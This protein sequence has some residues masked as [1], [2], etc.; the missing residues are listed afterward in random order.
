MIKRNLLMTAM[1]LSVML[2]GCGSDDSAS[3]STPPVPKP[4]VVDKPEYVWGAPSEDEKALNKTVQFAIVGGFTPLQEGES[5][6]KVHEGY[7]IENGD[8]LPTKMVE[9]AA[10]KGYKVDWI[11]PP[12][13]VNMAGVK[14]DTVRPDLFQPG[15]GSVLD[16]LI[17][18]ADHYD[19]DIQF[20]K[21]DVL[22]TYWVT[23]IE[24]V[25]GD[26]EQVDPER[27]GETQG[28][29]W[30]Y[31]YASSAWEYNKKANPFG[32]FTDGTTGHYFNEEDSYVRIDHQAL[33]NNVSI[34]LMPAQPGE[35]DIRRQKYQREQ[36]RLAAYGGK[37]IIPEVIIDFKPAKY[38]DT[39]EVLEPN[40]RAVF[41][42]IEITAHNLR[43]DIYQP[44]VLT[45]T[46]ILLSL[47][48]QRPEVKIQWD[49]WPRMSSGANVQGYVASAISFNGKDDLGNIVSDAYFNNGACGF[50]HHTGEWE[51]YMDVGLAHGLYHSVMCKNRLD[52]GPEFS[53]EACIG[54]VDGQIGYRARHFGAGDKFE[55]LN[56]KGRGYIKYGY[57]F[58]GNDVHLTGDELIVYAPE[59]VNYAGAAFGEWSNS[60]PFSGCD[61]DSPKIDPSRIKDIS[62]ARA[63]LTETHFGWKQPDCTTCHNSSNSH[64]VE[65]MAP[66][67]CA[68]CHSNNGAPQ[69]HGDQTCGFCHAKTLEH[70]GDAFS[71]KLDYYGENANFKEPES[72][73]T[74]HVDPR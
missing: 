7:F 73:L 15:R 33:K 46:D 55:N 38:A 70:H 47:V 48:D 26:A 71:D 1:T 66:W 16:M 12:T 63:P 25:T 37:N 14:L 53:R 67:E 57:P 2:S 36:D 61:V 60:Q 32:P 50:V 35:M 68:E 56:P 49:Y 27:L 40:K 51:N 9:D 19:L 72:C 64:V 18:A 24:G 34:I 58:G 28:G 45:E 11:L 54:E 44:G 4:P 8:L 59:Y 31:L 39:G 30:K 17:W 3:T 65:D 74:C 52:M 69:S 41:K 62:K 20:E 42:D 10:A 6:E 43:T 5:A 23:S 21:D 13:A 29:G 22:N